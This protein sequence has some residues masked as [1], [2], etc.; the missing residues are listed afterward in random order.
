MSRRALILIE[1]GTHTGMPYVQAAQRLGLHPITLSADPG[2]YDYLAAEG[3][4]SIRVDTHNIDVLIGECSRLQTT[5]EI[6]GITSVG[7]LFYATVGEL[8]R[9]FHLP[10]PNPESVA[11]CSDKYVQ[12]QLLAKA[13]VLVPAFR[14]AVNA[15]D[16]EG[17]I[18]EIGLPV[19]VKPAVGTGSRGVRLCRNVDEVTEHAKYLFGEKQTWQS[20]RG[21]L[22]EEF[23]QGPLYNALIMGNEVIGVGIALYGAPP[24]FVCRQMSYPAQATDNQ[25]KRVVD[26]SLNCLRAL[27]LGWGPT[28][29]EV[30][31]TQHGPMVIEVNPRLAGTP[32]PEL[33]HLAYGLDLIT[34]HIKLVTGQEWDLSRRQSQVTS[35]RFLVPDCDG[36]LDWID[37]VSQAAALPGVA[38]V[39]L[40]IQPKT[41]I[42]RKGDSS[43]RIGYVIATSP[44]FAQTEAILQRAVDLIRWSIKPFSLQEIARLAALGTAS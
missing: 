20:S 26:L 3:C 1:G 34:E 9:Y 16:I 10:G 35:A 17:S 41:P 5:Y 13:G 2:R 31:W 27:G 39:K 11:Q 32:D 14:L 19:V 25:Y 21:I 38:E 40:H 22:I 6:A 36:I 7:D 28:N 43:D 42:V 44:D 23:A 29:V 37:G 8:C 24:H 33:A 12:R 18:A 4:D 15:M 30:R